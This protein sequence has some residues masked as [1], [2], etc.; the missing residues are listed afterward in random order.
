VGGDAERAGPD[1]L[2]IDL[3]P[4]SLFAGLIDIAEAGVLRDRVGEAGRAGSSGEDVL[5]G[6]EEQQLSELSDDE[7]SLS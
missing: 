3:V 2:D 4:T 7:S 6:E 1:V 5:S